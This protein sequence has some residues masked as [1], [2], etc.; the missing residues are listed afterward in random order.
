MTVEETHAEPLALRARHGALT[1]PMFSEFPRLVQLCGEGDL[2]EAYVAFRRELARYA[3]SSKDQAAAALSISL[4]ADTVLERLT[5]A[6][7]HFSY[8]DQ[9]TIRRWS[10]RGLRT[11]AEELVAIANARG[12]LGREL[13]TLTLGNGDDGHL[14]LHIDQMDFSQLGGDPPKITIWMWIDDD[15]AEEAVLD[16]RDY[17][18]RTAEN[19]TY[20]NTLHV[21][22]LP[23]LGQLL[24]NDERRALTEKLLTVA[25]QGRSAPA[26]TVTWRNEAVLPNEVQVEVMVH[27]TMVTIALETKA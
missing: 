20:R 10:D 25:I 15:N 22:A 27:R 1:M 17:V 5:L 13:L 11:I 9:R 7:E 23:D 14:R 16:L 4:P 19:G 2:L 6:A 26:R 8:E 18:A 21:V 24:V 12:R 3:N